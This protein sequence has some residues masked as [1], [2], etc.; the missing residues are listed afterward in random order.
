ESSSNSLRQQRKR[1]ENELASVSDV[2]LSDV[3]LREHHHV[4]SSLRATA[5]NKNVGLKGTV[6]AYGVTSCEK[7]YTI[8][9]EE[10]LPEI[11]GSM[12]IVRNSTIG[13]GGVEA[14]R[15]RL[16]EELQDMRKKYNELRN[17]NASKNNMND[18]TPM[19]ERHEGN[20]IPS[21]ELNNDVKNDLE[22]FKSCIRSM[23]T[24]HDK[25]FDRDDGK[26]T[27]V[28]PKKKTEPPPSP[29]A[30]TEHVNAVFTRSGKS[31]DPSKTQKDPPPPIIVEDKPIKTSKKADYL[32]LEVELGCGAHAATGMFMCLVQAYGSDL[33]YVDMLGACVIDF[34][35]GWD[36]HLPINEFSYNNSYHTS[37]KVAPFKALYGRK[38]EPEDEIHIDDKLHF[39]EEPVKIMDREVKR[40]K[41]SRIPIIKVRWNS[42]RGP[43]F[44]WEREDQ[45]LK[46]YPHLFTKTAPSTSDAS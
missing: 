26:T 37:I 22:H 8:H 16:N 10:N 2:P 20:Y 28:L 18:D 9:G 44:T 15:P 36:R 13:N 4:G 1:L 17:G 41:Q 39:I 23:R 33:D 5:E 46:K 31:N 7:T 42:R 38:V 14:K 24:V 35:N 27:D 11:T 45:F 19:C 21:E 3:G 12:A 43:E 25:L 30:H 32:K 29:R 34:G 40:L 6:I